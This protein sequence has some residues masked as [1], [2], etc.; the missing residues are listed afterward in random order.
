M[1]GVINI[2]TEFTTNTGMTKLAFGESEL[3]GYHFVIKLHYQLLSTNV[4]S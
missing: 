2:D 4:L 1:G 3:I